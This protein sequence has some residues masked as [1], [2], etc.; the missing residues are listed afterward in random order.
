MDVQKYIYS[1]KIKE[2]KRNGQIIPSLFTK[3]IKKRRP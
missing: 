1:C 2:N 3:I